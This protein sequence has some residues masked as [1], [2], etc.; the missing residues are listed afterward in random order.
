MRQAYQAI[1]GIIG[2]PVD[3]IKGWF[4]QN[5]AL[6]DEYYRYS[7]EKLKERIRDSQI[8]FN[9]QIT[10]AVGVINNTM[11][12]TVSKTKKCSDCGKEMT[13]ELHVPTRTRLK[14]A[15]A[16]IDRVLGKPGAN[17]KTPEIINTNPYRHL[18]IEELERRIEETKRRI[19]EEK[20]GNGAMNTIKCINNL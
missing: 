7:D 4:R 1:S 12:E 20:I 14:A 13:F 15:I 18:S 6:S 8:L 2:I 9:S 10:N 19:E 16:V 17:I 3:T 5:G 11:L